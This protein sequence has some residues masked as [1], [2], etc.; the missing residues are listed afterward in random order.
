[1]LAGGGDKGPSVLGGDGR[2]PSGAQSAK[3]IPFIS[4]SRG[5][6]CLTGAFTTVR[7]TG[8][9]LIPVNVAVIVTSAVGEIPVSGTGSDKLI[10]ATPK[11]SPAVVIMATVSSE[12]CQY[13]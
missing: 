12:D 3:K 6:S 5:E 10:L 7:L 4:A 11:A 1:M 8:V 2:G 9:L 13:T